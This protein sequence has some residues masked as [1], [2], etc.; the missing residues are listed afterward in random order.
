ME[1]LIFFAV[2][3]FFSIIESIARSRKKQA[4][5]PTQLPEEWRP[6]ERERD[7]RSETTT[8][9]YD[10][11]RSYDDV[12]LDE[13]DSAEVIPEPSQPRSTGTPRGSEG[14][15]PSDIWEEIAGLARGRVE[16]LERRQQ[17]RRGTPSKPMPPPRTTDPHRSGEVT[18]AGPPTA[19]RRT[20]A[21]LSPPAEHR[22]HLAHAEYGTDPSERAR[23]RHD[24][25]D[26]LARRLSAD[27]RSVRNQ[28]RLGR[29][30]LRQAVILQEVLGPPASMR[31]EAFLE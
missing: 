19:P 16:D 30:A 24:G 26:P 20:M 15:I 3:I 2:I 12:E 5:G 17:A 29:H 1:E 6:E 13:A 21:V 18:R 31:P 9:T 27:V 25:L 10:A 7:W 14:M 28:L 11:E 22:V 23:S 4:G 8:A